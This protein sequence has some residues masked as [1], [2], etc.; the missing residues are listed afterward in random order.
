MDNLLPF[1]LACVIIESTPGPNMAFLALISATKGRR[2]G[3]V[4]TAGI[5]LGLL[6][7][8]LLTAMGLAVIIANSPLLYQILRWGGVAYLLYLAW[9]GWVEET[10]TSP[11]IS[12]AHDP[13][14]PYFRHGL[15]V[16]L[17]NPKAALF[18]VT[19]LPTFI[20]RGGDPLIEGLSLT[21]IYVAIATLMHSLIVTLAGTLHPIL[22]EPHHAKVTRRVLSLALAAVAIWFGW[23]SR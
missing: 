12:A 18:Y 2:Y 22:S 21:L 11:H 9:K 19:I 20:S 6:V 17:L 16:N 14:R 23:S 10:E 13:V 3:Y 7:V 4:T 15:I 5:A 8:G 1:L